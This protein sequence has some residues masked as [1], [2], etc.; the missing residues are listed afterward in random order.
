MSVITIIN[1]TPLFSTKEEALAWAVT[2]GLVGYHTHDVGVVGYMG[3]D[4]HQQATGIIP[5]VLTATTLPI[6]TTT[7][8]ATSSRSSGSSGY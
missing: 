8:T 1:N 5:T 3:G 2:N 4:T 6:T 7:P